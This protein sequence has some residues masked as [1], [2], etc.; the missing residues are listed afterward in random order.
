MIVRV[1]LFDPLYNEYISQGWSI[2]K[3]KEDYDFIK[4]QKSEYL[5]R[6]Y[7]GISKHKV[8]TEKISKNISD[9]AKRGHI[10]RKLKKLNQDAL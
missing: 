7:K 10:T 1:S 4:R 8:L 6:L 3:Q 5:S 9:G 2:V